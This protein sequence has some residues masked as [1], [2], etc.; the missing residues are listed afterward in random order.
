M[1]RLSRTELI[2]AVEAAPPREG[3]LLPAAKDGPKHKVSFRAGEFWARLIDWYGASKM[4]DFGEWPGPDLCKLIDSVRTREDMGILLSN[5]RS[6]HLQ[7]P[8]TFAEIETLVKA[9][10]APAVDLSKL[11]EALASRALTTRKLT[12]RQQ[13]GIP[14]WTYSPSGVHI[15]ADGDSPAVFISID[16]VRDGQNV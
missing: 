2:G 11:F 3:K 9:C 4:A 16:E 13:M 14:R 12:L 15:P 10:T 6:K 7:W 5:I 8:P 1:K